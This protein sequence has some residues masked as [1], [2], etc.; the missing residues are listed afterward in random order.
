MEEKAPKSINVTVVEVDER[1]E[2]LNA[3]ILG[4][5]RPEVF[6][7]A[8]SE[9]AFVASMLVALSMAVC[10]KRGSD[11][12]LVLSQGRTFLLAVSWLFYL[13]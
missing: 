5:K 12:K 10:S 2:E 9:V 13:P 6:T 11:D 4:R 1:P 3:E 7:S 8:W